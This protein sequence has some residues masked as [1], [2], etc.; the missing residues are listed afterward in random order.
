VSQST[1]HR[2]RVAALVRAG[3]DLTVLRAARR[4]L[5]AANVRRAVDKQRAA[6]DLPPVTDDLAV[7]LAAAAFPEAVQA[8]LPARAVCGS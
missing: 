7:V 2:A 8:A 3:A 6:L 4:E 5:A 1:H